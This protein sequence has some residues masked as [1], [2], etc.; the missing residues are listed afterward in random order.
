MKH[1]QQL[2]SGRPSERGSPPPLSLF[3]TAQTVP[4]GFVTSELRPEHVTCSL[5]SLRYPATLDFS[6]PHFRLRDIGPLHQVPEGAIRDLNLANNELGSLESVNRFSQLK[7]LLA[8]G[9]MLQIGG[10]LVLRLPR[11]LEID[12][13]NNRLVAIPPLEELP[14]LQILRLQR[15]QISTNWEELRQVSRKS[16]SAFAYV[17]AHA[18]YIC[19]TCFFSDLQHVSNAAR[20]RRLSQSSRVELGDK[21]ALRPSSATERKPRRGPLRAERSQPAHRT[22]AS[23]TTRNSPHLSRAISHSTTC[24]SSTCHSSP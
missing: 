1:L 24:H 11:L 20:A 15:N 3:A 2:V 21:A 5:R 22:Q 19:I 18:S 14:S 9:N 17:T 10:G 12:L 6:H 4:P 13:S 7:R 8:N 23:L 16:H